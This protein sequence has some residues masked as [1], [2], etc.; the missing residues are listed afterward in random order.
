MLMANGP[1]VLGFDYVCYEMAV[2]PPRDEVRLPGAPA[3][4]L[5]A[6]RRWTAVVARDGDAARLPKLT[7]FVCGSWAGSPDG[8]W[9]WLLLACHQ[10]GP[11]VMPAGIKTLR[12]AGAVLADAVLP[13]GYDGRRECLAFEREAFGQ[14]RTWAVYADWLS[15][16]GEWDRSLRCR[17][18]MP[19]PFTGKPLP[20][21]RVDM[22]RLEPARALR[23]LDSG[24]S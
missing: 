12:L 6:V 19:E 24:K 18:V 15:D 23:P 10:A 17:E 16:R 5:P 4:L 21:K 11:W 20:F 2:T 22:Y 7:P 8:R 3:P 13:E 14:P 1:L 9:H